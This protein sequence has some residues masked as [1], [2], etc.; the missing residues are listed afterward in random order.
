MSIVFGLTPVDFGALVIFFTTAFLTA[1]DFLTA[2]TTV[3]VDLLFAALLTE[4]LTCFAA[5]FFVAAF[6]VVVDF[7]I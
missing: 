4:L 3:L 6:F 7:A 5:G 2:F 1:G